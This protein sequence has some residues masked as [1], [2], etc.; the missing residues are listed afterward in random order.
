MVTESPSVHPSPRAHRLRP[1][2]RATADR[3]GIELVPGPVTEL[4]TTGRDCV[5]RLLGRSCLRSH[6]ETLAAIYCDDHNLWFT[7][8]RMATR[9]IFTD[10]VN[11]THPLP[12]HPGDDAHDDQLDRWS[13]W[14]EEVVKDREDYKQNMRLT[15]EHD[16]DYD[17][18]LAEIAHARA[19]MLEAE[20]R[21]R[22]L[23]A[24]G[25]EFIDPRPYKLDDLAR[26]A[27]MSISGVRTAYDDDEIIEAARLTGAKLR[28]RPEEAP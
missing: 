8:S 7:L 6:C 11:L 19:A 9:D 22:L 10:L 21:M 27:G 2:L 24:Y 13:S 25:R 26:A 23:I 3:T 5:S 20:K 12:E 18:L 15:W 1:T 4:I 17:P 28:R 16:D 14:R